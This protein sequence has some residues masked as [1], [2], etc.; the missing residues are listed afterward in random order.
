MSDG[1]ALALRTSR[2]LSSHSTT[3]FRSKTSLENKNSLQNHP[4]Y[5]S[6]PPKVTLL[7]LSILT[8]LHDHWSS[9]HT[10]TVHQNRLLVFSM[11]TSV[12]DLIG[13]IGQLRQI[14]EPV[15]VVQRLH[16]LVSLLADSL[17]I[18]GVRIKVLL[19]QG[20][21]S[22]RVT[23]LV[24][25]SKTPLFST[26]GLL[27]HLNR[28]LGAS[29]TLHPYTHELSAIEAHNSAHNQHMTEVAALRNLF[30][31]AAHIESRS[32]TLLVDFL[33]QCLLNDLLGQDQ[34]L[35]E[36]TEQLLQGM[37][38]LSVNEMD[39]PPLAPL[40]ISDAALGQLY[41][42]TSQLLFFKRPPATAYAV[43]PY[44]E[45][46]VA[47]FMKERGVLCFEIDTEVATAEKSRLLKSFLHQVLPHHSHHALG[48]IDEAI[49]SILEPSSLPA[50][51]NTESDVFS[52]ESFSHNSENLSDS[53]SVS[54]EIPQVSVSDKFSPQEVLDLVSNL[55]TV[56]SLLNDFGF[57]FQH[58]FPA[59]FH[60]YVS[61]VYDSLFDLAQPQDY[62]Y[63]DSVVRS[64]GRVSEYVASD[65]GPD[66]IQSIVDDLMDLQNVISLDEL[67]LLMRLAHIET[68][69]PFATAKHILRYWNRRMLR[70]SE[71]QVALEET[72]SSGLDLCLKKRMFAV[73]FDRSTKENLLL[74]QAD[75]YF[76]KKT[77]ARVLEQL[78]IGKQLHLLSMDRQ[79]AEFGTRRPFQK[80]HN[81]LLQHRDSVVMLEEHYKSVIL[82][83]AMALLQNRAK[84][85]G[86]LRQTADN[87]WAQ[88]RNRLD[89]IVLH[90]VVRN[91]LN[92]LGGE[93]IV[94]KLAVLDNTA[95]TLLKRRYFTRLSKAHNLRSALTVQQQE[96]R[97]RDLQF[98]WGVWR[99][100]F[101][102]AQAKLLVQSLVDKRRKGT[103]FR[104]WRAQALNA[105]TAEELAQTALLKKMFKRWKLQKLA[106]ETENMR[107]F[108]QAR[109]TFRVWRLQTAAA[110]LIDKV[111][112]RTL[113]SAFARWQQRMQTVHDRYDDWVQESDHRLLRETLSSWTVKLQAAREMQIVADLNVQRKFSNILWAKYHNIITNQALAD[114]LSMNHNTVD[115]I[116]VRAQFVKWHELYLTRFEQQSQIQV[117][118][119][120][121]E[122]HCRGVLGVFLKHWATKTKQVVQKNKSLQQTLQFFNSTNVLK[123]QS[124]LYW[125]EKMEQ[126]T[127]AFERAM[128]F[129]QMLLLKKFLA[130]WY[131]MFL[132]KHRHLLDIAEDAA[133][134]RDYELIVDTFTRWQLKLTKITRR[135]NQTRDIFIGKWKKKSMLSFFQLW[136]Y[137]TQK[138]QDFTDANMTLGSNT[139]PLSRKYG[140][141]PDP[142]ESY[143]RTPVKLRFG[144]PQ[145]PLKSGSSPT[146]MLETNQKMRVTRMDALL[147][148]YR[149]VKARPSASS[150]LLRSG[151][152]P[153]L[154]PPTKLERERDRAVRPPPPPQFETIANNS[155][156]A[157]AETAEFDATSS[158]NISSLSPDSE[159]ELL[160][161]AKRLHRIRPVVVPP[162]PRV[163][164]VSRL[165][166]R[167]QRTI[168]D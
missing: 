162:D 126:R 154:S 165:R 78:W 103:I 143:L 44:A 16:S 63:I 62:A 144:S 124:F 131:E 156:R 25:S 105:H 86:K 10:S 80:W 117:R 34:L 51:F 11:N 89:T 130:R 163:S 106:V 158:P 19:S 110:S 90:F 23:F 15:S 71:L 113:R 5:T 56:V 29:E 37:S 3:K 101:H 149:K 67:T 28:V 125:L 167:M 22:F 13:Q 21:T 45:A 108:H 99:M 6:I 161:S 77:Q 120:V 8:S 107:S 132:T 50:E 95:N 135:N 69:R 20:G 87:Q 74:Q 57:T 141:L 147:E 129:D 47:Y 102:R 26:Q 81:K 152:F 85:L 111:D 137:K 75:A 96:K 14:T 18:S 109:V 24:Q 100:N 97:L 128:A 61:Y 36:S 168:F 119:F 30:N 127:E 112:Q 118:H 136:L 164:P 17:H 33:T 139:S 43:K 4:L 82:R 48:L 155:F 148:R 7:P 84:W 38:L 138:R 121:D 73:W 76:A 93:T 35:Q 116:L 159:R 134:K 83:R 32:A 65:G 58:L 98:A 39:Y 140:M 12:H 42:Q 54:H 55:T 70:L 49:G 146:R 133:S 166:D 157:D 151:P 88:T 150:V 91:W 66:E 2:T 27:V 68:H 92:V 123:S 53:P 31:S 104:F 115:K 145:T 94:S 79:A 64:I 59:I 40:E 142:Y 52:E 60:R 122:V 1:P 41:R 9:A 153:R 72:K 46:M 114:D 160:A